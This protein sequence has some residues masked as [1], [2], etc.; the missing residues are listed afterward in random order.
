MRAN[1]EETSVCLT[2][3][4]DGQITATGFSG[5]NVSQSAGSTGSTTITNTGTIVGAANHSSINVN[6]NASG[7]VTINNTGTIGNSP[8]AGTSQAIYESGGTVVINNSGQIYGSVNTT[9]TF[10]GTFNNNAGATWQA[11]YIDDEGTIVASGAGSAITIIGTSNGIDVA[12]TGTGSLTAAA[13][14]ALTADFLNIGQFAGSQGTVNITGVGT[15][16]NTTAGQ[17]Q[18][19]G[20]GYNGTASLTIADH[21][22][23]STTNMDIAV[24]YDLG[25]VDTL[26]VNNA[27]LNVGQGLTIGDAGVAH[28]TVENGGTI[29]AGFIAI[30]N[31]AGSSGSLGVDGAGTLV[32]TSGLTLGISGSS[33]SLSVTNGAAVDVGSDATTIANAVHVGSLDTLQGAGTINANLVNDGHVTATGATLD[34]TGALT[35]SGTLTIGTGAHLEVGS[36]VASTETVAFQSS[37]GSLIVDQSAGFNAVIS[38]FSGNGTLSGSD[39]IDL[40]DIAFSGSLSTIFDPSHDTLLVSDGTNSTTLHFVGTYVAQNF[41]F[42]SDGSGGTI[43]YDPPVSTQGTADTI[44]TSGPAQVSNTAFVFNLADISHAPDPFDAAHGVAQSVPSAGSFQPGHEG[45]KLE[46]ALTDAE[47]LTASFINAEPHLAHFQLVA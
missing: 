21:A 28:A 18:N 6:E 45:V 4:N 38:G 29:T 26:D 23:V 13:G 3:E 39:Q 9:N 20:V 15:T 35:G 31:Q 36:T 27:T 25:V 11:G 46:V 16:L 41:K 33:A 47:S 43:V 37:T 30:A 17:F 12:N 40:K 10:T 44:S 1:R 22:V 32:T 34:V 24:H 7:T 19:I 14:A 8:A 2:L 5:I 42:T